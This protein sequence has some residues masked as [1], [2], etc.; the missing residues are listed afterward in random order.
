MPSGIGPRWFPAHEDS[1]VIENQ[2][3]RNPNASP[4]IESE[5]G[6]L[7]RIGGPI[8]TRCLSIRCITSYLKTMFLSCGRNCLAGIRQILR[9]ISPLISRRFLLNPDYQSNSII[10]LI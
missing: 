7:V 6:F 3:W 4:S 2:A 1:R 10:I 8:R 9:L 5:T